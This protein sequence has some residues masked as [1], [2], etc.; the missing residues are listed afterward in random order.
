M[1]RN[2]RG[3]RFG[4]S[5]RNSGLG[6]TIG[7]LDHRLVLLTGE[8]GLG[9]TSDAV[10]LASAMPV[11]PGMRILDAGC[12]VGAA[13]LCLAARVP[14]LE[15][16]GLEIDS[17]LARLAERNA[18]R[19][20]VTGCTIHRADLFGRLPAVF[21]D[22]FDCVGTNPPWQR[23]DGSTPSP[24]PRR[25]LARREGGCGRRLSDWMA[26]CAHLVRACGILV[27]VLPMNRIAD[28]MSSLEGWS[29]EIQPLQSR[30]GRAPGRALVR[31]HR[32]EAPVRQVHSSFVLH[33]GREYSPRVER[34]LRE[35]DAF[36]WPSRT[37]ARVPDSSIYL[38]E[39][40]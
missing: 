1:D 8:G 15:I 14:G 2:D 3:G 30:A 28:A 5:C 17:D 24:D 38:R 11:R 33:D 13:G 25:A 29:A 19:N 31:L 7:L 27:T 6:R 4:K 10:F 18:S 20:G 34:I 22:G 16:H 26:V 23:S 32:S 21:E 37:C 39:I 36:P 9:V 12:G 40:D 35:G